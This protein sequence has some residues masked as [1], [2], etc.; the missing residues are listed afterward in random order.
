MANRPHGRR[1]TRTHTAPP[2][3]VEAPV[4]LIGSDPADYERL[5]R[6]VDALRRPQGLHLTMLHLGVLEELAR[7]IADWTRG[8]TDIERATRNTV[9]WLQDLPVLGAF[10]GSAE[11]LTV[12]G[13]GGVSGLELDVPSEVHE[14]QVSLIHA[15][16]ELLDE[17]S[18][19]NID[20]FILSSHALGFRSPRWTPHVAVGRPRGGGSWEIAPLRV[21]FGESRI[22][23]RHLLPAIDAR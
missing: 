16:H 1:D 22:R 2:I 10:S 17:L 3:T 9:A 18:V 15:L 4:L 6:Y 7:D 8:I 12:L 20:D 5:G 13:R 19:D 14:F 11:R 23:N 21:D